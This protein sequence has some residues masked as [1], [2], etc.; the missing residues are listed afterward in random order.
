[1]MSPGLTDALGDVLNRVAHVMGESP[2]KRAATR[3]LDRSDPSCTAL[4]FQSGLQI[5]CAR[6]GANFVLAALPDDKIS[7][8]MTV[9]QNLYGS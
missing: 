2:G 1:M 6:E 7:D 4:P 5:L 8:A 3:R 9:W